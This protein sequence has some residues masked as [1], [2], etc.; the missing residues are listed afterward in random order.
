M[1]EVFVIGVGQVPVNN[2]P[3]AHVAQIGSQ[4]VQLAL[5]DAGVTP[6][7]IDA[8]YVGN[9]LSGILGQQKQLGSLIVDYAGLGG[10][11]G[12]SVDAACASGGAALRLGYQHVAGGLADIVV[13][14]GT[15]V[16]ANAPNSTVT[17]ALAAATDWQLEGSRGESFVSLNAT[18]MRAYME[19]HGVPA[20]AFAPFAINAHRNALGN[21]NALLHKDVDVQR[22]LDSRV[23]AAPLRLF[24][25]SPICNGAAA[26]VLASGNVA[27]SAEH[28]RRALVQIVASA[29]YT[30]SP[31]LCRRADPLRLMAVENSTRAALKQ[32]GIA[33][34]SVD[35]FELHDAY[36]I[37]SVLCLE[38][39]GF[40]A[41]GTATRLGLE[42]R[43]TVDGELPIS[44]MGGLKAR[45]HPVGATGVYQMVEA[46][47]QFAGTAG[48]NQ[49]RE[50]EHALLQNVGGI[51]STVV[52]HVVR[53]VA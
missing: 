33:H 5:A 36:T 24:D 29:S 18:L 12:I 26:V 23:V 50:P 15:E 19:R 17:R 41:P 16:M 47:S 13:I 30:D 48:N 32:A 46:Y 31:A 28:A 3:E 4:A 53:R 45:G 44:T 27:R 49:L 43:I 2:A 35:F 11:E 14:C 22:Y 51:A 38:S 25:I 1:R 7:R 10:I 9:M 20:E 8:L 37:M 34:D 39:A 42:K 52:T 21:P 40:A 6:D